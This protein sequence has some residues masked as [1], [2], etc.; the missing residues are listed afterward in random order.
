LI[1]AHRDKNCVNDGRSLGEKLLTAE[2]PENEEKINNRKGKH[3]A[4]RKSSM[5]F[6]GDLA[7]F[8]ALSAV[9]SF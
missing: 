2:L 9:K 3:C 1:I 5:V 7:P 4:T 8:S 6:L